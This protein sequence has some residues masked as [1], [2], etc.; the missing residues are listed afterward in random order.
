VNSLLYW[1][2][3]PGSSV[4]PVLAVLTLCAEVAS[5]LR[6]NALYVRDRSTVLFIWLLPVLLV[7][8]PFFWASPYFSRVVRWRGH[9]YFVDRDGVATRLKGLS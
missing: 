9:R 3:T 2:L 6:M 1:W 7:V 8:A 5:H 4:G